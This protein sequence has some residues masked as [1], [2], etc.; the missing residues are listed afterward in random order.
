M[1]NTKTIIDIKGVITKVDNTEIT[2]KQYDEVVDMFLDL[3]DAKGYCF[4][5]GTA[6][7]SQKE[8]DDIFN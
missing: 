5:G 1:E 3:L 2:E 7:C 4:G 8:W 6:H